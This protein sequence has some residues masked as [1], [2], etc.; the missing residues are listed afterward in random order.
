MTPTGLGGNVDC[1][2]QDWIAPEAPR[3]KK[4]SESFMKYRSLLRFRTRDPTFQII[5]SAQDAGRFESIGRSI[6]VELGSSA[7]MVLNPF[8]CPRGLLPPG[9]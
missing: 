4:V 1:A 7:A 3:R 9:S 8:C 2:K 6:S 5:S